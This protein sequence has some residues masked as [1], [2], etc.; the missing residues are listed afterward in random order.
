MVYVLTG[1][2]AQKFRLEKPPRRTLLKSRASICER[3]ILIMSDNLSE[4]TS[5]AEETSPAAASKRPEKETSLPAP[6]ID[7][8]LT[9]L[10][11]K[12]APG[13]LGPGHDALAHNLEVVA[14]QNQDIRQM[15]SKLVSTR[16]A[17][18]IQQQ[19]QAADIWQD[20]ALKDRIISLSQA[21]QENGGKMVLTA[22]KNSGG[23]AAT[24]RSYCIGEL[25]D[26]EVDRGVR[27]ALEPLGE[28]PLL[29]VY[30][31]C[32]KQLHEERR[33]LPA[34]TS[35]KTPNKASKK[36]SRVKERARRAE[37][38]KEVESDNVDSN[39]EL[40]AG[41]R[42]N[43]AKRRKIVPDGSDIVEEEEENENP[44]TGQ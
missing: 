21:H 34:K 38:Q 29:V 14:T 13:T 12:V 15:L 19:Q 23:H 20:S 31:R 32:S 17:M 33:E 43:R 28:G 7:I 44:Y 1:G 24:W 37:K 5:H 35:E 27:Q 39:E 30:L 9:E 42:S 18:R 8:T 10:W 41:A 4:S 36:A 22:S 3:R 6:E 40:V 2:R 16:T 25:Q 11:W 26:T